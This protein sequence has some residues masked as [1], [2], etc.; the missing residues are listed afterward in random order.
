M[1]KGEL[2]YKRSDASTALTAKKWLYDGRKV[3]QGESSKPAK[4]VKARKKPVPKGFQALESYGAAT[5]DQADG[6]NLHDKDEDEG[7][8]KL[9]GVWQTKKWSSPRVGPND[10]IPVNEF[11]NVELALLNPGLIHLE[12]RR[13]GVPY[14]PYLLGFEGRGGNRTPTIRGLVVYKHNVD[15]LH[16][17]HL[18][19]E[20]QAVENEYKERQRVIYGRWKRLIVGMMTKDRLEREYA[21]D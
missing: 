12:L 3:N 13:L 14:A 18:E 1:F 19:F 5:S 8:S 10:R 4:I 6:L 11:R 15:L 21:N 17:A 16:E 9:Y 7:K 20:I 2:A